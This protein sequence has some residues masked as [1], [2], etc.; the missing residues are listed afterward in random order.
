[1]NE[2]I[3]KP[4]NW[5]RIK[6]TITSELNFISRFPLYNLSCRRVYLEKQK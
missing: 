5:T 6:K 4:H 3:T 2:R 1:M